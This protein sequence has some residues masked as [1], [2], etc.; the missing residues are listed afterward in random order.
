MDTGAGMR[1]FDSHGDRSAQQARP[2][3]GNLL[4]HLKALKWIIGTEVERNEAS[5]SAFLGVNSA[6]PTAGAFCGAGRPLFYGCS[7]ALLSLT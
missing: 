2:K 5:P 3:Y 6:L 7:F 4:K 1:L